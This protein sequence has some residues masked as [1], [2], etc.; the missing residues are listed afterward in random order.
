VIHGVAHQDANIIYGTVIDDE[1]G[2]EI[3]VTVIAA[4]FERW[5]AGTSGPPTRP[6]SRVG[7]SDASSSSSI[8][9]DVDDRDPFDD[10]DEIDVPSF[11]K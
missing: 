1:M 10:S 8:F 3:K 2:D 11:L 7:K 9:V 6:V 5:D 4:S